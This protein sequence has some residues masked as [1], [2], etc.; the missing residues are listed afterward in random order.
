MFGLRRMSLLPYYLFLVAGGVLLVA[1]RDSPLVSQKRGQYVAYLFT[2][3]F[4]LVL[5]ELNLGLVLT[6]VL[7][8]VVLLGADRLLRTSK[9]EH[10]TSVTFRIWLVVWLIEAGLPLLLHFTLRSRQDLERAAL[11]AAGVVL[12]A[13]TLITFLLF[14]PDLRKNA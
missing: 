2:P 11:L 9:Q 3:P 6:S 4:L 13:G 5:V 1:L 7:A 10:A 12:F 14:A 8:F